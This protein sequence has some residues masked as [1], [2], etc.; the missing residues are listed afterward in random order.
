MKKFFLNE[1]FN[2]K[3]ELKA[4]NN[5]RF[6]KTGKGQYAEG[7][8]FLGLT[9]PQIRS[10]VKKYYKELCLEDIEDFLN[11]KYHEIRAGA[12]LAAVLKYKN[13]SEKEKTDI[14][15]LY[16]KLVLIYDKDL[17]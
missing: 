1:I 12:L 10:I 4:K 11:N 16:I 14:Y 9:Y 7:D 8:I 6:Y 15:N 17:S 2:Q 3:D 13:G 5:M